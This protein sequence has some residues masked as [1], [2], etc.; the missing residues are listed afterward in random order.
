MDLTLHYKSKDDDLR[1]QLLHYGQIF[2]FSFN[3]SWFKVTQFFRTFRWQ[4]ACHWFD[5][6][7]EPRDVNLCSEC[8]WTVKQSGP[9]F[10][11]P[12]GAP[13]CYEWNKDVCA[14]SLYNMFCTTG[15]EYFGEQWELSTINIWRINIV[16]FFF[17]FFFF[18]RNCVVF[19]RLL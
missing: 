1:A 12:S 14:W 15:L 6:Y 16:I 3:P 18:P 17:L 9:C 13:H 8:N 7:I 11:Q 10:I 19:L 5:I 4:G 2:E